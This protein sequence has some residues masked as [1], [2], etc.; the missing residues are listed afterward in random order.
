MSVSRVDQSSV[1]FDMF[2][3]IVNKLMLAL[4]L[5]NISY[6]PSRFN[7]V[8]NTF[9]SDTIQVLFYKKTESKSIAAR[10][11]INTQMIYLF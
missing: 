1:N 3:L 2:H 6:C 4:E 11:N 5:A 10:T 7:L 8:Q 9:I